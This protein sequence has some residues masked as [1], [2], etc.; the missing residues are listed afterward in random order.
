M[1]QKMTKRELKTILHKYSDVFSRSEYDIGCTGLAKHTIDT[2]NA[3]PIKQM[4]RKTPLP[5]IP[6][7]DEQLEVMTKAGAIVPSASPWAFNV[8]I[9]K[10]KDGSSRFCVDYRPLN[11]VTRKDAYPLPR[12][13]TCL[14]ALSGS[15]Y[16]SSF[17]LRSGYHN[18][19]M[20]E[21]DSDKTSFV[22]RRGTFK[23]RVLPFG[24]CNAGATFQRVMDIAM[25]GLNFQ[26]CLVYLD[27]IILFSQSIP[28]HLERLQLLLE[29]LKK[30]NL[31]LKPSKCKL[32]R[33]EVA[34]LGHVVSREG[35][36]T[37]PDK[38]KQVLDWPTPKNLTEVR[39]FLGLTS[40]YRKFAEKFAAVAAPLHALTG[41]NVPFRWSKECQDAFDEL[42][43]RLTSAPV[44][45]MPQDDGMYILDTDACSE[46]IGGVLHQIQDGKERVI[47]YQ[48]RT[49]EWPRKKL[50]HDSSRVAGSSLLHE[51]LQAISVGTP[52]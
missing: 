44:L 38:I 47:A 32:L 4:L 31:K 18:V 16:L 42:K 52:F 43:R 9:V 23:F 21:A 51:I 37:D 33:E 45:A 17:D 48:S 20:D 22:T 2:G 14:D 25:A 3:R 46:G 10:K 19:L 27:D 29:A 35:I 30:A 24:L 7:I 13:D 34:F 50:L 6:I 12:I 1:Q 5:H 40:Y 26:I 41:K 49:L 8:V 39:A 28:Q 36:S 15:R 11:A